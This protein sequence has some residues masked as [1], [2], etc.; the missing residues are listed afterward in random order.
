[1]FRRVAQVTYTLLGSRRYSPTRDLDRGFWFVQAHARNVLASRKAFLCRE[2]TT[3]ASDSASLPKASVTEAQPLEAETPATVPEKAALQTAL[4]M[5][6]IRHIAEAHQFVRDQLLA[7]GSL[8]V[9]ARRMILAAGA[10]IGA[11][12]LVEEVLDHS[13]SD[14]TI[15]APSPNEYNAAL[16]ACEVTFDVSRAERIFG[17]MTARNASSYARMALIYGNSGRIRDAISMASEALGGLK[18]TSGFDAVKE[19]ADAK[20]EPDATSAAPVKEEQPVSEPEPQSSS[21]EKIDSLS[22]SQK[23]YLLNCLIDSCLRYRYNQI[24]FDLLR[25]MREDLMLRPRL[26]TL[27]NMLIRVSNANNAEKSFELLSDMR[28]PGIWAT[29]RGARPIELG[30][31]LPALGCALRNH[32]YALGDLAW[33]EI[34]SRYLPA[35][36]Q[37]A[38]A[39]VNTTA[40]SAE[41]QSLFQ[42]PDIFFYTRANLLAQQDVDE[43]LGPVTSEEGA[44]LPVDTPPNENAATKPPTEQ[45]ADII[46]SERMRACF[47]T[48]RLLHGRRYRRALELYPEV[49]ARDATPRMGLL[50]CVVTSLAHSVDRVD[51]A[52]FALEHELVQEPAPEALTRSESLPGKLD[53]LAPL[54]CV[55]A[56]SSML[57]DLDRAFQTYETLQDHGKQHH[58]L[59][60][61]ET[62]HALLMGCGKKGHWEAAKLVLE[63]IQEARLRLTGET[64]ERL[65]FVMLRCRRF[66]EA[67]EYLRGHTQQHREG[68]TESDYMPIPFTAYR[69]VARGALRRT[70]GDAILREMQQLAHQAGYQNLDLAQVG[71]LGPTSG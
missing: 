41:G 60:N 4:D 3:S 8:S 13:K 71:A 44:E 2:A 52:H 6:R 11:T 62:F 9:D 29:L 25:V 37:I 38:L 17:K 15:P 48:L 68:P 67:V 56:A 59:P 7:R 18:L 32:H 31:L 20:G 65:I 47:E 53:L 24:A 64:H 33:T 36:R 21:I 54:N 35:E 12:N 27:S 5:L 49:D 19:A 14:T 42:V 10:R 22:A 16:R 63:K 28:R 40:E 70:D 46:L 23:A 34:Q 39:S 1:M 61:I 58:L 66:N 55:I 50:R 57:G 69:M 26:M 43:A 45:R 30:T 51:A